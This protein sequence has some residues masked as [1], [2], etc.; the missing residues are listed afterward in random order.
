[1]SETL[2]AKALRLMHTEDLTNGV[3]NSLLS[4]AFAFPKFL[5][6]PEYHFTT[7]TGNGYADLAVLR[8]DGFKKDDHRIV[9]L[10]EGKKEGGG[11]AKIA[12][13]A[14]QASKAIQGS[15]RGETP[16]IV[17]ALGPQFGFCKHDLTNVDGFIRSGGKD[18][19][20]V[21][22]SIDATDGKKNNYERIIDKL[23]AY[24]A[25]F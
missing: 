13:T 3:W 9:L 22:G 20:F 7:A 17:F 19:D 24:A 11:W 5:V 16:Y 8:I 15:S 14:R 23:V 10:Y 12:D 25:N 21:T 18:K 2:E 6:V 1:M 4:N